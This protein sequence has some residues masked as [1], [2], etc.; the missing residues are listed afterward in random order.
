M[1][2]MLLN[3]YLLFAFLFLLYF[4][5]ILVKSLNKV[6]IVEIFYFDLYQLS[7]KKFLC[8]TCI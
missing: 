6:N 7:K 4:F 1:I 8:Q 5:D 3:Q 2:K